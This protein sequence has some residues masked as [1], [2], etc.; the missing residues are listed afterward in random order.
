M[1]A[2]RLV[3]DA[4]LTLTRRSGGAPLLTHYGPAGERTELSVASF[5]NWVAKTVNLLEELDLDPDAGV[6]LPVLVE[7]PAH[8]MAL[9]WPFALWDAGRLAGPG[10]AG[11]ELAVIGPRHPAA[12][13]PVTLA[14]SLDAWGRA[15]SD[16]PPGVADYSSAALAQPDV[17]A[18]SPA[19]AS[20]AAW[21]DHQHVLTGADLAALDP[22]SDR[23]LVAPA[24]AWEAVSVLVRAV[25]GGGSVVFVED[26]DADQ[27]RLAAAERARIHVA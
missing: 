23:V 9:I 8:W 15:L 11:A 4:L 1:T 18:H 13:A 26:A 27:A 3:S 19:P 16:L 12:V 2:P 7:R 24:S 21:T 20:A 17:A 25:L 10:D 22:I 5:A 6:A 14:C